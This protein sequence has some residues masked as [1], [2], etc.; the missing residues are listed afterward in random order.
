MQAYDSRKA[1]AAMFMQDRNRREPAT[2]VRARKY[3]TANQMS[4]ERKEHRE[5]E[6][7]KAR[8]ARSKKAAGM[9]KKTKAAETG[10]NAGTMGGS[11]SLRNAFFK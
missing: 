8:M 11:R 3:G 2:A 10:M 4:Y 5:R 9:T 7:A 6:D 1:A